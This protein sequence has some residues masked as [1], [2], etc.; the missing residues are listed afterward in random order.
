MRIVLCLIIDVEIN[1]MMMNVAYTTNHYVNSS[2]LL[3]G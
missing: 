1:G 3:I 2:K